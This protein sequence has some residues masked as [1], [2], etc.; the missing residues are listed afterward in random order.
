[1]KNPHIKRTVLENGIR[2]I[3]ERMPFVRSVAIG[4]WIK[5]GSG[6]ETEQN[7]GISHFLEHMLF[8]GTEK[9]SAFEIAEGLESLGGSINGSTGKELSLYNVHVLDENTETAVDILTDLIQNP[10]ITEKDLELERNVILSEINHSMED[11]EEFLLDHF[12]YNI[13]SPHPLGFFIYGKPENVARF[14]SREI[15]EYFE[16]KYIPQNIVF[17][18]SGNIEHDRFVDLVQKYYIKNK[19]ANLQSNACSLA[20][21]YVNYCELE[22]QS[23]Q[24]AHICIGTRTCGVNDEKKYATILLEL[25]LG[26]GMSS[27]LFQNIREKY[28]F[29]Y[30]VY[31]FTD[32]MAG[33][34]V[35][36]AYMACKE[37]KVVQ[38]IRLLREEF[39]KMIEEPIPEEELE[40]GKSHIKGNIILGLESSSRRMRKNGETEIYN[41][42]H[43]TLEETLDKIDNITSADI[44]NIAS[45]VFM[46]NKL[47]I[48]VLLPK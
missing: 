37:S 44:Q 7:N 38:S 27:R 5:T 23:L 31:S 33:T 29:A 3:T 48:T 40:R 13:Y 10:K 22:V 9:R 35:L 19:N 32:I 26:G 30:N 47:N 36:G 21:N 18:A 8:K 17:S 15:Y 16:S 46:N 4:A 20:E 43:L 39:N 34:G 41:G 25:I 45:D 28:G 24:Q 14:S 12:Y 2:I 6:D 42:M 11:P 1:M